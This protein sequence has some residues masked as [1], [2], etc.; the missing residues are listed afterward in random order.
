MATS[1]PRSRV[2]QVLEAERAQCVD[3]LTALCARH[4][5]EL[6]LASDEELAP[7]P[8]RAAAAAA[9]A[10][11]SVTAA[12][13][14]SGAATPPNVTQPV[15]SAAV[16]LPAVGGGA[17]HAE[18]GEAAAAVPA[19]A[20][21]E[22]PATALGIASGGDDDAAAAEAP[23]AAATATGAGTG[24]LDV[25]SPSAEEVGALRAAFGGHVMEEHEIDAAVE[26]AAAAEDFEQAEVCVCVRCVRRGG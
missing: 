8:P 4:S 1:Y 2:A 9:A 21:A 6:G 10:T 13:T 18:E 7:V 17:E 11:P 25:P 16:V 12:A 19:A 26:R 15:A 24:P 23:P 20:A 5:L 14:P 3:T 22:A